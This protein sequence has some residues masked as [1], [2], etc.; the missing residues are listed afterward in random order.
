MKR[1]PP[2]C[3]AAFDPISCELQG[4]LAPDGGL[5]GDPVSAKRW[6][7]HKAAWTAARAH[8]EADPNVACQVVS[9][10]AMGHAA[11]IAAAGVS[12]LCL[13]LSG[14]VAVIGTPAHSVRIADPAPAVPIVARVPQRAWQA[15]CPTC[16]GRAAHVPHD[17][18]APAVTPPP[19]PPAPI[20]RE[21]ESEPESLDPI[22]APVA[23]EADEVEVNPL[24]PA[25][26]PPA[27]APT[28]GEP[29]AEAPVT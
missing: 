16:P 12:S 15:P 21:A 29:M 18:P 11:A 19:A 7:W 22:N 5:A 24:P 6:A 26:E 8:E 23:P 13:C 25:L 9:V 28:P 10:A 27:P 20:A 1:R 2:Y 3:V 4:Y 14:C 17:G